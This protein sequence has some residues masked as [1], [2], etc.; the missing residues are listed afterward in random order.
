M[1]DS[2][3]EVELENCDT[4][5]ESEIEKKQKLIDIENQDKKQDAQRRMAWTAVI[6]MVT[7]PLLLIVV[8][9]SRLNVFGSISDILFLSQA[10]IVAAFYGTEAYLKKGN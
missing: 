3:L 8:P 2:D 9:E 5:T 4:I 10:G 6:S 1:K 7:Y